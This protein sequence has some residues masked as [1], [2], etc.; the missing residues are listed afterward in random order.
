MVCELGPPNIPSDVP[1]RRPPTPLKHVS[2]I[3][4]LI[5]GGDQVVREGLDGLC[6]VAGLN[7]LGVVADEYGLLRLDDTDAYLALDVEEGESMS[8]YG[9]PLGGPRGPKGGR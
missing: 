3:D 9:S 8:T 2:S 4:G 7:V 5:S 6:C 1:S